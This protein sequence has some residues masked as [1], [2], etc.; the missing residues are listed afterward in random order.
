MMTKQ[1]AHKD[2]PLLTKNRIEETD[3]ILSMVVAISQ[4]LSRDQNRQL[5]IYTI[6]LNF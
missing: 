6:R 3:F 1:N 2:S 5:L 4:T